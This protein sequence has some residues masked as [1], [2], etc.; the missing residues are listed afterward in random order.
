MFVAQVDESHGTVGADGGPLLLVT[1]LS[2]LP[3]LFF[4]L[5]KVVGSYVL[6]QLHSLGSC[7]FV[8]V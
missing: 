7:V 2:Q 8:F 5:S 6:R 4:F 3:G 1:W